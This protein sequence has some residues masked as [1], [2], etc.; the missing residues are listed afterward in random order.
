MTEWHVQWGRIILYNQD[1]A[2]GKHQIYDISFDW[3]ESFKHPE[4]EI[5]CPFRCAQS[6]ACALAH[7]VYDVEFGKN[8][9]LQE[10][11]TC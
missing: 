10:L 1:R 11:Y 9:C 6:V 5:P 4:T 7:E 3:S 8:T 2:V